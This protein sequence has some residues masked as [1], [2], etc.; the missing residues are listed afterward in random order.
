VHDDATL[1]L[2]PAGA[3]VS[4]RA[5]ALADAR[6]LSCRA[7]EGLVIVRGARDAVDDLVCHLGETSSA[8][9]SAAVRVLV[10]DGDV[11][12]AMTPAAAVLGPALTADSLAAIVAKVAHRAM[13]DAL[14]VGV[15]V[16]AVYQPI[17]EIRSGAT[18]AFEG[19]LRLEH[20]GRAVPPMDV[21]RAAAD[22]G[23]LAEADAAARRVTIGG[24]AGW[25]GARALFVNLDPASVERPADLDDTVAAVAEAGLSA[26]QVTLEADV[27]SSAGERRHL[28]RVLEHLRARGFGIALDDVT[29]DR[30]AMDLLR[31][32]RPD[33]VK[34]ASSMIGDLPGVVARSAVAAVVGTAHSI[35]ARVVAKG[36]ETAAQLDAVLFVGVDDAQGWEVGQPMRAPGSRISA[37]R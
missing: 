22:A 3:V 19:L 4:N 36:I 11:D 17:I 27:P 35:G 25:I 20:E 34:I 24:A 29:S 12:L 16:Q 9:E 26:A 15:G 33:V 31:A 13:L 2:A 1:I 5:I 7:A 37:E 6:A 8:T 23:R 10:V 14:F 32:V 28:R 30:E 18:S 21:F